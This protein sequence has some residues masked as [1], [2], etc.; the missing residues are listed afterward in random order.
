MRILSG[1]IFTTSNVLSFARIVL[2]WP[3]LVEL[4]KG[5]PAGNM[6]AILWMLA[7]A[8]TDFL[9]GFL[10]RTL[11]QQSD[12]GRVLDPLADKVAVGA[13][14]FILTRTHGLPLWFFILI[15]ARDLAILMVAPI[16]A[17]RISA[18]P[19][20]NWYGKV[21][22]TAVG[23][24]IILFTLNVAPWKSYLLYATVLMLAISTVSY[25]RRVYSL[26]RPPID[27]ELN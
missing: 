21:A 9:D 3:I 1:R 16:V 22:V 25:C 13:A 6:A 11:K 27:P 24:V 19:E 8:A 18:V 4:R 5:T 12:L 26:L 14:A 2:I 15:I 20:S 10:A 7:A 23:L 17:A